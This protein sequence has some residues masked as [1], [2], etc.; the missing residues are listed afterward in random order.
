MNRAECFF[1]PSV[2]NEVVKFIS[3]ITVVLVSK[4]DF[5]TTNSYWS[6]YYFYVSSC[7]FTSLSQKS[8]K[9]ENKNILSPIVININSFAFR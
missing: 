7:C 4:L 9:N 1:V 2:N 8:A 5:L 3:S 6:S